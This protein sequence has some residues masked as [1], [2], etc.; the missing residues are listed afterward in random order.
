MRIVLRCV[1]AVTRG[2]LENTA[3]RADLL[4]RTGR[5]ARGPL[6][7]VVLLYRPTLLHPAPGVPMLERIVAS[8][9]TPLARAVLALARGDT[10]AAIA[11]LFA[12]H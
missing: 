5:S 11:E 2:E 12:A 3:R 4:A 6:L 9:D 7:N 8:N 10:R 1:P